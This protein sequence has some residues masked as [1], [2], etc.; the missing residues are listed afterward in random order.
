MHAIIYF[1]FGVSAGSSCPPYPCFSAGSCCLHP[2]ACFSAGNFLPT[3][4]PCS[5]A[6]NIPFPPLSRSK[7]RRKSR[8]SSRISGVMNRVLLSTISR[9]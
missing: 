9:T 4:Y 3:P 8:I 7:M 5:S 6:S 1:L 2:Y